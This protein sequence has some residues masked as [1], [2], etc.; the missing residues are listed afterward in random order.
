MA[1][2]RLI[3]V[4]VLVIGVWFG[5]PYLQQFHSKN[6][7]SV[8]VE[9]VV[10]KPQSEA[11]KTMAGIEACRLAGGMA[12]YN[13]DGVYEGCVVNLTPAAPIQPQSLVAEPRAPMAQSR[14]R[15]K[16]KEVREPNFFEQLFGM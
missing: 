5:T 15:V 11:D 16:K 4:S 14:P 12:R 3:I 13:A 9:K 1:A 8:P 7:Q 6:K 10:D 2:L